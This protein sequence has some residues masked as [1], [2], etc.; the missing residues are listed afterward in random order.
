MNAQI[1]AFLD[2][3]QQLEAS[4]EQEAKNRRQQ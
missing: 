1:Q 2:R 4:I 3:I